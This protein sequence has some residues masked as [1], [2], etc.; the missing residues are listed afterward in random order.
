ME[1]INALLSIFLLISHKVASYF[2]A[3]IVKVGSAHNIWAQNKAMRGILLA[4]A[5]IKV[6]SILHQRAVLQVFASQSIAL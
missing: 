1:Q 6:F 5:L 2:N 3:E 4:N